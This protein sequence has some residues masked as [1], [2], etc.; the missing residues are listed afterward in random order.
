MER[1]KYRINIIWSDEDECY[2]V[3]L[4]E[5]SHQLQQY[6]THGETYAEAIANAQEVLELLIEDY[7]AT[8]KP[9]PAPQILQAV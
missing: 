7:E 4:P 8:G 1:Y 2:L 3:E 9:L 6:F 5:F